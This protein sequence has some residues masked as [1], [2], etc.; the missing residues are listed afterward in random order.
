[1]KCLL[2]LGESLLDLGDK[3]EAHEILQRARRLSQER[4]Y[5]DHFKKAEQLLGK[6]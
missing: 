3:D 2:S 6:L 4:D 1:M 5:E